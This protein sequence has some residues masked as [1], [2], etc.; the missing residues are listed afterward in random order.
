MSEDLEEIF[1][2][3][4]PEPKE[5]EAK[6]EEVV[7]PTPEVEP[8]AEPE[9]EP[10]VVATPETVPLAA[11]LEERGKRQALEAQLK[12]ANKPAPEPTPDVFEDPEGFSKA[13]E[14]RLA[15]MESNMAL[16]LSEKFARS[17]H[18]NETVDKAWAAAE[19][20]GVLPQFAQQQDAYGALVDWHKT[21]QVREEIGNDPAAYK[22]KLEA[23]LRKEI[24]AELATKQARDMAGKPAPS[25]AD[26]TGSGGSPKSTWGGPTPLD[27]AFE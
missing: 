11:H 3:K 9:V 14:G 16:N 20:A 25:M 6:A 7:E 26:V 18:G 5:P 22:A 27:K 15:A 4:E 24:Q 19:A 10:E 17:N 23:D 1:D 8:E 13:I 21:Q 2:G 12:E